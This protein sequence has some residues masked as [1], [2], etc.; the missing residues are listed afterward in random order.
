MMNNRDFLFIYSGVFCQPNGDPATKEQ[1]VD[2]ATGEILVSDV[3]IK[4]YIRDFLSEYA[5]KNIYMLY[6]QETKDFATKNVKDESGSGARILFLRD[7]L[8]VT[9]V[10]AECIDARLFGAVSTIK[11]DNQ[12]VTGA[13]QI[14]TLNAS[15][16]TLKTIDV[17]NTTVFPSSVKNNQGS[18]GM[19]NLVPYFVQ[20]INGQVNGRTAEINKVTTEDIAAMYG[21]MWLSLSNQSSRSK[22]GQR[23]I[24][25]VDIEYNLPTRLTSTR[26]LVNFSHSASSASALRENTPQEFDIT[27]LLALQSVGTVAK[28]NYYTEDETL[29]A[30]L[31]QGGSKFNAMS[32][33]PTY[34][35]R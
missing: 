9:D 2:T 32:L 19:M 31:K 16:H 4:R 6:D 26:S 27:K 15:M 1:R 14:N 20:L 7:K 24:L 29:A 22:Q 10:L 33:T 3:R 11:K 35:L 5:K 8:K 34:E 23:P 17:S 21:A 13:V 18:I 28:V 25:L 30:Q 12:Q